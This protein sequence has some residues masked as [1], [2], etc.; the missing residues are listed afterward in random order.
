MSC[1]NSSR[2]VDLTKKTNINN[3]I[4]IKFLQKTKS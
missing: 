2:E 1:L 3:L 4:L